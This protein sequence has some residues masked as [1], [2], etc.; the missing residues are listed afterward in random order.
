MNKPNNGLVAAI[1]IIS[2]LALIIGITGHGSTSTTIVPLAPKSGS[3]TSPDLSSPYISVNGLSEYSTEVPLTTNNV[4]ACVIQSPSSTSTLAF[5]NVQISTASSTQTIWTA[6]TS[7]VPT[8]TTSPIVPNF[9]LASGALG[10]F[11]AAT[12][13]VSGAKSLMSPNTYVVW[14]YAGSATG[15]STKLNGTCNAKFIVF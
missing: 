12:G 14:S 5:T 11:G 10:S 1:G 9:T 2:V 6:A 15:D 3:V 4:V 13:T 7:T 8:A